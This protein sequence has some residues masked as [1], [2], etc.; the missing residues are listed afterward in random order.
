METVGGRA[1]AEALNQID[2][3]DAAAV[4]GLL[5]LLATAQ[6]AEAEEAV[7]DDLALFRRETDID[8]PRRGF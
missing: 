6:T 2:L 1:D 4:R 5:A 7:V 3:I 8:R